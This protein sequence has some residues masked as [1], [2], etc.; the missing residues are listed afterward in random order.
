MESEKLEMHIQQELNS[1]RITGHNIHG[2]RMHA[3]GMFAGF[4]H[5]G[6]IDCDR[7]H[8]L[9]KELKQIWTE[10]NQ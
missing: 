1:V 7:F 10:R 3:Q 9:C 5:A 4:L 2:D 6:V 8:E